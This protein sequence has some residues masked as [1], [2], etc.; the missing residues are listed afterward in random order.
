MNDVMKTI[1]LLLAGVMILIGGF[2]IKKW[3]NYTFFYEDSVKTEMRPLE[4]RVDSL[5]HN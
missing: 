1:L 2:Y 4:K 5:E 3:F